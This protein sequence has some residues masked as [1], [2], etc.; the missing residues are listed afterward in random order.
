MGDAIAV[1]V[2]VLGCAMT[3]VSSRP[4]QETYILDG[5]TLFTSEVHSGS[6]RYLRRNI[7]I[8]KG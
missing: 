8:R 2:L 4:I 1:S 7:L 6:R 3:L 5:G